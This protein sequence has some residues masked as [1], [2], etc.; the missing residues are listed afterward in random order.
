MA[1]CQDIINESLLELSVIQPGESYNATDLTTFMGVLNELLAS[2]D[3]EFLN[4]YAVS[5]NSWGLIASQQ[6]YTIG[7]E[8]APNFNGNRPLSIRSATIILSSGRQVSVKIVPVEEYSQLREPLAQG[9]PRRLYDDGNYPLATL[10]LHPVPNQNFSLIL[11]TWLQ[12]VVF[13]SLTDTFDLPPGYQR[14]IRLNLAVEL[15][16]RMGRPLD[17]TLKSNADQAKEALRG[18]NA[19]PVFGMAQT[20]QAQGAATPIPPQ[21]NLALPR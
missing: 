21:G 1:V 18:L 13:A 7:T 16:A 10:W 14:A 17:P 20:I 9:I 15:A 19:P 8:G 12:L 3:N 11:Y 5:R 4:V 6:S 2:W